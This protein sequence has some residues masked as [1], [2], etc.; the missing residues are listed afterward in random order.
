MQPGM[1]CTVMI[2]TGERSLLA[3]LAQPM[4]RRLA[5]AMAES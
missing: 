1:P 4:M 3:Y 5:G 2:K